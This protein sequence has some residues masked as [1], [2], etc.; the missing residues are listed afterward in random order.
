MDVVQVYNAACDI[1]EEN[2]DADV[3][4]SLLTEC[5]S[6]LTAEY[7]KIEAKRSK[8]HRA[9]LSEVVDDKRIVLS[10]ALLL[11]GQLVE[12][13]DFEAAKEFS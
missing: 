13:K 9:S 2:G 12:W 5:V 1:L 10:R 4:E 7:E 6:E 11:L 3:A 8:R